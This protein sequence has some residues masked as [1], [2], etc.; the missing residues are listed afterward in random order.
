MRNSPRVRQHDPRCLRLRENL[1]SCANAK[2]SHLRCLSA[3]V[4][5]SQPPGPPGV[6]VPARDQP[7][8]RLLILRISASSVLSALANALLSFCAHSLTGVI[9]VCGASWNSCRQPTGHSSSYGDGR[10]RYGRS[11]KVPASSG[12]SVES[13]NPA[14]DCDGVVDD[15]H[16]RCSNHCPLH[17]F[18]LGASSGA[19][20]GY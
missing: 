4:R 13:L 18:T 5:T 14:L 9:P 3:P 20:R 2:N 8:A 6:L 7:R 15:L 17:S 11:L 12:C 1:I 16:D 19:A 10:V